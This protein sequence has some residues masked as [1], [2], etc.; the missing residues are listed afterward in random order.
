MKLSHAMLIAGIV[1]SLAGSIAL[2]TSTFLAHSSA[3]STSGLTA[4]ADD[5]GLLA[6]EANSADASP[7]IAGHPDRAVAVVLARMLHRSDA[8]KRA[9][10]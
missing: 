1:I 6:A 2:L 10:S 4:W 5:A 3:G 7:D 8:N 9:G